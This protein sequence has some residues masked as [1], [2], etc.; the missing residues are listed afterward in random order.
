MAEALRY[1]EGGLQ[2]LD[3]LSRRIGFDYTIYLIVPVQ[4]I[5][6][7]SHEQTLAALNSVSPRPIVATA[8]LFVD[9]PQDYYFAYDG[10]LNPA[11]SR[12]LANFLIS[13]DKGT[14]AGSFV[15]LQSGVQRDAD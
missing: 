13:T 5:I 3:A 1:T 12:R 14:Q 8:P 2:E 10:H 11:G 6:R 9:R 4:D 15:N 7:G